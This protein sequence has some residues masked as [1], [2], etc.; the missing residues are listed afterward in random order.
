[1]PYRH[2]EFRIRARFFRLC[3]EFMTKDFPYDIV[4]LTAWVVLWVSYNMS[5]VQG[6]DLRRN[7]FGGDT[8]EAVSRF[9]CYYPGGKRMTCPLFIGSHSE[10][11]VSG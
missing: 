11:A 2:R 7:A 4:F 5:T 1:M 6:Y 3:A 8:D 9:Y 10:S